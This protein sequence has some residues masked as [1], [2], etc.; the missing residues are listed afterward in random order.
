MRIEQNKPKCFA[1]VFPHSDD[2]TIFAGGTMLKLL[3]CGWI[4]YFIRLTN[5]EKDSHNLSIGHTIFNIEQETWEVARLMGITKVF[6]FNY[7][8]H[9]LGTE[10]VTEIRHRLIFLF[11]LL[12]VDAVITFDPWCHNEE[13]PDHTICGIAVEQACWMA[14]RALDVP[15]LAEAGLKPHKVAEKYYVGRHEQTQDLFVDI[16]A[17]V[18]Q[19]RVLLQKN[20]TPM[21]NMYYSYCQSTKEPLPLEQFI[22][23]YFIEQLYSP[24]TDVRYYEAFRY[25]APKDY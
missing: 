20:V 2:F 5:D 6:D 12:G 25:V 10:I 14:G 19:K 21:N 3:D 9:Y 13:N 24:R 1:A 11:R 18:E 22:D 23:R 17:Y 7:K 15:E 8:N 16:S 4:G